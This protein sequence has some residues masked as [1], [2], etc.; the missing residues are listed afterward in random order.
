MHSDEPLILASASPRRRELL[1][2]L[3]IPF[4]VHTADIDESPL[5]GEGPAE[6]VVRLSLSKAREIARR[7]GCGW[8]IA[9]DTIVVFEEE[10]LGK[11]KDDEEALA[12]L[13]RMRGQA[14][15]VYSGLVLCDVA[16]GAWLSDLAA[17]R[18]WMRDYAEEEMAVYVASGDPMDKAGAY[19]I[20]HRSFHPVDCVEGCYAS[21]MG[22]PL[23]H[24]HRALDAWG[25]HPPHTPVVPCR[26]FTGHDCLVYRDILDSA[27]GGDG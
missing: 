19:A 25:G 24:L 11:P 27:P 18:V 15:T 3:G 5:Q 10:I 12:M 6:M 22:F 1:A 20:Q 7:L 2:L 8:I 14:H 13:Q 21:V 26:A 23:C 9:S 17:T 16:T 4:V